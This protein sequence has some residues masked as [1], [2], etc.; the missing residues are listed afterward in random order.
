MPGG[1][2]TGPQGEGPRT[3][4]GLGYCADNDQPGYA[5][6]QQGQGFG[7]R[8]WGR[9]NRGSRGWRN[10]LNAGFWPGR[11][12]GGIDIY[13]DAQDQDVGSLKAQMQELQNTLKEVQNRLDQFEK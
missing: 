4:R 9:G 7:F 2:R 1:D 3:G 5:S 13:S 12:R 6:P 11:G 10:R 8:R